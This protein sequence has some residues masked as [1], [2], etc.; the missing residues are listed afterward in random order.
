[1]RTNTFF[2]CAVHEQPHV[3]LLHVPFALSAA[4]WS[5]IPQESGGFNCGFSL[6][7]LVGLSLLVFPTFVGPSPLQT[8][9]PFVKAG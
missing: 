8:W 5:P 9:I 7:S 3:L 2:D 6:T 1:M 4:L